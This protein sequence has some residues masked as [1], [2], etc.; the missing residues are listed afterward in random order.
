M[1][2][3]LTGLIMNG[4]TMPGNGAVQMHLRVHEIEGDGEGGDRDEESGH[5]EQE[6]GVA[7]PKN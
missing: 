7:A 4:M 5:Y 6:Q 3:T 2:Y 1:R